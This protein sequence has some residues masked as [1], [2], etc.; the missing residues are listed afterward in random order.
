MFTK[1]PK[2][3]EAGLAVLHALVAELQAVNVRLDDLQEK[4]T[5]VHAAY[6]SINPPR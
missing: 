3:D 1:K 5:V 4:I 6:Q 2:S